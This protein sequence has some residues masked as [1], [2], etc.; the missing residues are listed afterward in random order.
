MIKAL[1]KGEDNVERHTSKI[2]KRNGIGEL[3]NIKVNDV[4]QWLMIRGENVENPVVLFIHGGPGTAQIGFIAPYLKELEKHYTVVNWDQRGSGLSYTPNL[5]TEIMNIQQF[6]ED[7]RS[8]IQYLKNTFKKE[9]VY[10]IGH[11]WGSLLGMKVIQKYPNLVER[12]IGVGQVTNWWEMEKVSYHFVLNKAKEQ[13]VEEALKELSEIGAPPYDNPL[14]HISIQRKW[15]EVFGG[16]VRG[17]DLIPFLLDRMEKGFEYTKEDI[18]KWKKGTSYSFMN[19]HEELFK[20]TLSD[21][22]RDVKMPIAFFAGRY[23]YNTPSSLVEEYYRKLNA[24]LKQFIWF[25]DSAHFPILEE[26]KEFTKQVQ[27]FFRI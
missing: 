10:L 4:D 6:V 17:I 21:E 24:P 18:E 14:K 15:L 5:N 3:N 26:P 7:T 8:V 22:V 20:T 12:Y 25:E 1:S 11:S 19:M 9:K 13:K 23:D 2:D 27:Q 16:S